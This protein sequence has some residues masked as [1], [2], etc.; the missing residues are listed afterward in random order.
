MASTTMDLN[1]SFYLI[2]TKFKDE[3]LIQ[4]L[5]SI[6]EKNMDLRIYVTVNLMNSDS[7][8]FDESLMSKLRCAMRVKY[9]HD[10]KDLVRKTK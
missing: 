1:F 10:P 7:S 6:F 3:Y 2:L 5:G 9:S 4:S 8:I